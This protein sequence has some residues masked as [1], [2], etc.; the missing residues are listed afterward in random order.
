MGEEAKWEGRVGGE[1]RR[2]QIRGEGFFITV[3]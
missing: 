3:L 1:S 2:S